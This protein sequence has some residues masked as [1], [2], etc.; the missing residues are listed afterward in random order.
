MRLL[1]CAVG[2]SL[3]YIGIQVMVSLDSD[4]FQDVLFIMILVL[5]TIY[6]S[7]NA[8]AQTSFLGNIGR[9]PAAYI[10]SANDG[11]GLGGILPAVI[12]IIILGK[13]VIRAQ[14]LKSNTGLA[15]MI[16]DQYSGSDAPP[17]LVGVVAVSCSLLTLVML[18][19]SLLAATATPFYKRHAYGDETAWSLGDYSHVLRSV[20]SYHQH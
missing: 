9:F 3:C 1:L 20:D 15:Y 18:V 13:K 4:T 10:G 6:S 16:N 2:M 17:W 19:P 14:Y 8:I 5:N 7:I 12:S 11:I